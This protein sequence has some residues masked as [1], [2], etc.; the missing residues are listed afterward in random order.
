MKDVLA[1]FE[2][3]ARRMS[4]ALCRAE[5]RQILERLKCME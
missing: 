4:H 2:P 3:T 5:A 1:A